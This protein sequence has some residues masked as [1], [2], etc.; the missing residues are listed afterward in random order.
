MVKFNWIFLLLLFL[1]VTGLSQVKSEREFRIKKSQFPPTTLEKVQPYLEGVRRLRFYKEIDAGRVSYEVKFKKARLHYSV[2]YSD[3]GELEDIEV[4][5]KTVDIPSESWEAL[6]EH[7]TGSF[8]KYKVR[9]IQQQYR[10]A[11]FPSDADTF[12][13]AFQ[14][15]LLPEIRYELIV[16]A[17][18]EDGYRDF[19]ITYDARGKF[20]QKKKSL[21]PNYDH[22][23]Y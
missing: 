4:R 10:R 16:H 20:I 19:E 9:K 17:K 2:E 7:L 14:N 1:G 12:Q 22:V 3:A 6:E 21:P 23:L 5:I 11:S 13:N 15:L 8:E 18:T